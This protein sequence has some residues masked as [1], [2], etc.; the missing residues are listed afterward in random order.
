MGIALP[1]GW[2]DIAD[3]WLHR[4]R[5]RGCVLLSLERVRGLISVGGRV[6]RTGKMGARK[7]RTGDSQLGASGGTSREVRKWVSRH[8]LEPSALNSAL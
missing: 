3:P 4:F 6:A 1:I 2:P 7:D 5:R 8:A